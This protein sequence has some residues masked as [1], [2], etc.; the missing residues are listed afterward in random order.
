M[1]SEH[2]AAFEPNAHE[3]IFV[4]FAHRLSFSAPDMS[5]FPQATNGSEQLKLECWCE[6]I[7]VD[8]SKWNS[9]SAKDFIGQLMLL[10]L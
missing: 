6:I 4:S 3:P 8:K 1:S 5:M 9:N 2:E 7:V 10:H